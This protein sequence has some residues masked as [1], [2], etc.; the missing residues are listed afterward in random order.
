LLTIAGCS[1]RQREHYCQLVDHELS[2]AGVVAARQP[3]SGKAKAK[4][5][6]ALAML[7]PSRAL[8]EQSPLGRCNARKG[9][10]GVLETLL[11][12]R[13]IPWRKPACFGEAPAARARTGTTTSALRKCRAQRLVDEKKGSRQIRSVKVVAGKRARAL[14]PHRV[15]A[16]G[17]DVIKLRGPP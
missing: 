6:T 17:G 16:V 4:R 9:V 12:G 5:S 11:K 2:P 10:G 7:I 14:V 8:G 3:G 1:S 13:A 15:T